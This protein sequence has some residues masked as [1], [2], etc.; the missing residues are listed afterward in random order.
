MCDV[1]GSVSGFS[2]FT[3]LLVQALSDQFSKVRVFAFV[4]AMDEVTDI[5]KD[6]DLAISA[7][8]SPRRPASPSGTR[9]ATT[10]RRSAT[11]PSRS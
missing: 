2:G 4:N 7:R 3:M 1:S 11:S 5:V 8:A 10:A 9:A 6:T